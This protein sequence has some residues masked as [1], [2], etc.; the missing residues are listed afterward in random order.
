MALQASVYRG[1]RVR[2]N[3]FHY[4]LDLLLTYTE[5]YC[6]MLVVMDNLQANNY[7]TQS[8]Q[9]LTHLV[10]HDNLP[11]FVSPYGGAR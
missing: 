9:G 8:R 6:S 11:A 2:G 10:I 5:V 4:F 3:Y 7:E 1:L